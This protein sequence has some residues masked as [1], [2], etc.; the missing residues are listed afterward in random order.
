MQRL[1]CFS[2]FVLFTVFTFRGYCP[3]CEKKSSAS[4]NEAS[5]P[6]PDEDNTGEADSDIDGDTEDLDL[7]ITLPLSLNI[8]THNSQ[9]QIQLQE[10]IFDSLPIEVITPPPQV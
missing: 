8:L 1:V 7:Q 9:D 6:L 5:Y 10:F 4:T 3:D 2:L